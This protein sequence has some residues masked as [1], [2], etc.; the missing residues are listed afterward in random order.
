MFSG[1]INALRQNRLPEATTLKARLRAAVVKKMAILRQPYLF[2]PQDTK[3]NPPARHLLWAAVLLQDRENFEL[4]ADILVTEKLESSDALSLPDLLTIRRQLISE[5]LDEL[6][7]I[8]ND[9]NLK[10]LLLEKIS[11]IRQVAHH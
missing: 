9:N 2:W 10:T 8:V 4:A 5:Q 3:I 7:S 6:I 1:M 11:S